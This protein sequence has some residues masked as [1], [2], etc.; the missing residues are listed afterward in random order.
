M[1]VQPRV[2]AVLLLLA[3]LVQIGSA[4][5]EAAAPPQGQDPAIF[6]AGI[7]FVRVDVIVTDRKD[8]PVTN[9]TK[10]DFEVIEDGKVQPIEQFRLIKVDGTAKPGDPP[11]RQIRNRDDEQLEAGRDDVRVYAVLLDDYHV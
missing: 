4:Q 7:N 2:C 6:K 1:R 10:D 3:R 8:A 11:P 9:L 5:Q